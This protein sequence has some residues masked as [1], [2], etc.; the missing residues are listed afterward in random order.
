MPLNATA[1]RLQFSAENTCYNNLLYSTLKCHF[2]S[3]KVSLF[4]TCFVVGSG[5]VQPT[6][7]AITHLIASIA[8]YGFMMML[9]VLDIG[10]S[11]VLT[12]LW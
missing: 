1:I 6:T 9:D 2:F 12:H 7:C 3:H 4:N 8:Y 11:C 5:F 10:I